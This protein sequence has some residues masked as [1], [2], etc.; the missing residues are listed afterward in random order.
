MYL[1]YF[2]FAND[3]R[4]HLQK[5]RVEYIEVVNT[6]ALLEDVGVIVCFGATLGCSLGCF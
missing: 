4:I 3:G 6:E 5:E 1:L 2:V